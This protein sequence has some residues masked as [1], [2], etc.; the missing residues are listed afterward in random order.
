[1]PPLLTAG[2]YLAA[3]PG[4]VDFLVQLGQQFI[5]LRSVL[6][7]GLGVSR[8]ACHPARSSISHCW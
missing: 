6:A 1:V 8:L 3:H 4:A 2:Q 5:Q 7:A